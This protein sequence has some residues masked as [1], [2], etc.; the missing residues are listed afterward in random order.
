MPHATSNARDNRRD[1]R[2]FSDAVPGTAVVAVQGPCDHDVLA[3]QWVDPYTGELLIATD[4]KDQTQ[5]R[6]TSIDHIVP[7]AEAHLSGAAGWTDERR[8]HFAND[9]PGLRVVAGPLNSSKSDQDPTEWLPSPAAVCWYAITWISIKSEW[10][11]SVDQ[12]ELVAL[13]GILSECSS[14]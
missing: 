14:A 4:L 11:L 5:A 2:L 10:E 9:L 13:H 12:A 8:L 1:D 7:L 3:G 6:A